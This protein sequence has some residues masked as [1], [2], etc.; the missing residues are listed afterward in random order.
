MFGSAGRIRE[1]SLPGQA[2]LELIIA[3]GIFLIST[4][5]IITL[6]F[7]ARS[8]IT[9][10]R[11][12]L[13][14]TEIAKEGLEA[15]RLLRDQGWS[16]L[17][18][19]TYGL[20]KVNGNW[21]LNGTSDS[22]SGYSRTITVTENSANSKTIV[23]RVNW[24]A[25][26]SRVPILTL[27]TI[28]TNWSQTQQENYIEGDWTNPV[29]AGTGDVGAGVAGTDVQ[30]QA[31]K[32][33]LSSSASLQEKADLT[34]FDVSNPVANPIPT[35]S[36]V[37]LG[38]SNLT[39]IAKSGNYIY[40]SI[41]GS[42]NEFM[43][44]DVT[45]PTAPV[46]V[47]TVDFSNGRSQTVAVDGN[48][49]YVGL[50]KITGE[51]EFYA[52]DVSDPLNPVVRGSFEINGTVLSIHVF[53][54]RAYIAT[55][56]DNAELMILDVSNPEVMTKLGEFNAAGADDGA[57]VFVKDE[58]N[59]YLG[60]DQSASAHEFFVLNAGTPSSITL[61]GSHDLSAGIN[62]MVIVNRLAFMVT[63]Q[64]NAEFRI[65]DVADP[66]NIST[67]GSGSAYLNFPQAATG[68]AYENNTIY[69]SV[70]SNNALR[71]IRS[72]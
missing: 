30:V 71:I 21:Q 31:Q 55:S 67:Y 44:V 39:S 72:S 14:G 3:S 56:A 16:Q 54:N 10:T 17:P 33:Y 62:D 23:S 13:L 5:S 22:Q 42:T 51:A 35:I 1:T 9:D 38:I 24:T 46:A 53:D 61:K 65:L 60:R 26:S 43:V 27:S 37:N 48:M 25:T 63:E 70:R 7:G 8:L 57:S 6:V 11:Q 58:F 20:Q 69:C 36:S 19:G 47:K 52:I 41:S 34:L 12:S 32:A 59:V 18:E 4:S 28:L 45:V 64:P 68:I 29:S 2:L 66:T 40:G 49:L 15:A 50:E